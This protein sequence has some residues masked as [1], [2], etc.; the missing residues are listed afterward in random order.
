VEQ[1]SHAVS[2]AVDRRRSRLQATATSLIL[3]KELIDRARAT[4][5]RIA[6]LLP[7]G[8]N[9]ALPRGYT[10]NGGALTMLKVDFVAGVPRTMYGEHHR[11]TSTEAAAFERD[12]QDGWLTELGAFM[13]WQ[14]R[15]EPRENIVFQ[16]GLRQLRSEWEN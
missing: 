16:E 5:R 9:R 12:I 4:A 13:R 1:L 2:V 8:F 14:L 10:L 3:T 11:W 15:L 7:P 6:V